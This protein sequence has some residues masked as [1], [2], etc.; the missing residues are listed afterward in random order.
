MEYPSGFKWVIPSH[1][2][3]PLSCH[4]FPRFSPVTCTHLLHVTHDLQVTCFPALTG[5][6]FYLHVLWGVFT[7]LCWQYLFWRWYHF[8]V[9]SLKRKMSASFRLNRAKWIFGK[10]KIKPTLRSILYV[11][12]TGR[13]FGGNAMCFACLPGW[14]SR[15]SPFYLDKYILHTLSLFS[16]KIVLAIVA[17]HFGI[18]FLMRLGARNPSGRSNAK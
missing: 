17:P 13:S 16:S 12:V 18:A 6:V 7:C 14:F 9:S 4:V 1:S 2:W 11:G 15:V 10:V 8:I 5:H 3:R